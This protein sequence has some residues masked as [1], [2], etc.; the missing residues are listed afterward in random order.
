MFA[1]VALLLTA[2]CVAAFV[3][4][5]EAG[6]GRLVGRTVLTTRVRAAVFF[7]AGVAGGSLLVAVS[8]RE[9]MLMLALAPITVLS[10]LRFAMLANGWW[11]GWRLSVYTAVL[12]AIGITACLPWMPRPLDR[13]ALLETIRGGRPTFAPDTI[14]PDA[15]R[16]VRV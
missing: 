7:A 14:S 10:I 8:P 13:A 2:L 9:W 1:F 16:P 12:L 4:A 3:L 5:V 15:L 6:T 11:A